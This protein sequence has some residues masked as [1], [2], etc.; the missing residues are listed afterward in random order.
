MSP[1]ARQAVAHYVGLSQ[2]LNQQQDSSSVQTA[3][4][5]AQGIL[6]NAGFPTQRDEAWQYT[7]LTEFVK[8]HFTMAGASHI[9]EQDVQK[10]MPPYPVTKLVFVD[11]WFSERFSDDLVDLPRGVTIETMRDAESISGG[12]AALFNHQRAFDVEPFAVLNTALLADGYY[13]QVARH[14]C[15]EQPIFV[16]YLQTRHDQIANVRNRVI[17]EENAQITLVEHYA[18]LNTDALATVSGCTNV[19][20]ELTLGESAQCHQVIVQ[21]QNHSSYYFNNQ[22]IYQAAKSQ[23]FGFY[24]GLGS[25]TSRHQNHLWM[26]GERVESSQNSACIGRAG[27]TVDSRTDTQ[28]N[29][30]WGTSRQLHKFVLDDTA[31]GVFDGMIKVDRLAQKTDG[32]MDNKNLLLS[33]AAKMDSKPKLEI[34]ADDVKCSHGSATGQINPEQI[35]YL[36]ARGIA[37]AQA[38]HMITQAFLMEPAEAIVHAGVRHWVMDWLTKTLNDSNA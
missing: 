2:T 30:T 6:A 22:F 20:N 7:K 5:H 4:A 9:T 12:A 3:R 19:V 35:F 18:S 37:R 33:N 27:Q 8:T 21:T 38:V 26:N 25:V 24:A 10:F 11:G 16:L 14:T 15:L 28:H 1:V 13:L 17:I 34:Y 31:I 29:Q 23:F 36:Q 32:Q